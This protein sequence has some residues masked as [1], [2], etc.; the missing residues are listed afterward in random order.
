MVLATAKT[1]KQN[2]PAQLLQKPIMKEFNCMAKVVANQIAGNYYKPDLK[3][4]ALA[5]LSDVHKS[6]KVAK[7]GIKK[8]NRQLVGSE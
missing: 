6:L 8:R 2:K 5:S 3:A 7:S 1:K 4:A